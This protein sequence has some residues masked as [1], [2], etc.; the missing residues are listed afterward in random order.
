M[1][2]NETNALSTTLNLKNGENEDIV[3]VFVNTNLN[4]NLNSFSINAFSN[5][6]NND[7]LVIDATNLA[8]QTIA[9][10]YLEFETE[11]KKRAKEMGYIL[12]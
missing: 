4:T 10:Q 3:V 6:I 1:I 8:G 7:L 2:I 11:V 12:F 5:D 9:D